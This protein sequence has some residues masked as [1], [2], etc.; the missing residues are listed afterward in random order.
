MEI[1]SLRNCFNYENFSNNKESKNRMVL[2]RDFGNAEIL[3][4]NAEIPRER[5]SDD[6]EWAEMTR[7]K[8][9]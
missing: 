5:E 1:M 8:M 9:K 6:R 4:E 3:R 7:F 2:F